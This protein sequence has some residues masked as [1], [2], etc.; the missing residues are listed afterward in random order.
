MGSEEVPW[1]LLAW[2]PLRWQNLAHSEMLGPFPCP[3][4][5]PP[6]ADPHPGARTWSL[7]QPGPVTPSP[8]PPV[9]RGYQL[10]WLHFPCL[11]SD[12][13]SYTVTLQSKALLHIQSMLLLEG[14]GRETHMMRMDE[15]DD[16]P[17]QTRSLFWH[18]ARATDQGSQ[19]VP[20]YCR[21]LIHPG[22]TSLSWRDGVRTAL[23]THTS[24]GSGPNHELEVKRRPPPPNTPRAKPQGC[25]DLQNIKSTLISLRFR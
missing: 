8:A 14:K 1:A 2:S 22:P 3:S 16:L 13:Q 4:L 6:M 9:H 20:G 19:Q 15:V 5:L 17:S 10:S 12:T 11:C 23:P 7:L 18:R 25:D 21:E 24:P